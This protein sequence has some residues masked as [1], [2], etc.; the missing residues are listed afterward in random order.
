MTTGIDLD[1]YRQQCLDIYRVLNQGKWWFPRNTPRTLITEMTDTHRW[2][3]ARMLLRGAKNHEWRYSFGEIYAM[4][5][6]SL[7]LMGDHAQD[8]FDRERQWRLEHPREWLQQTLLYRALVDGL[9]QPTTRRG[10]RQ[11]GRLA[12]RAHHWSTCPRNRDLRTPD[13]TC[14]LARPLWAQDGDPK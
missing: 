9:P 11:L 10:R 1:Q 5:E 8:A 6:R 14:D 2:N 7:D 13:C 4:S 12:M 3:T